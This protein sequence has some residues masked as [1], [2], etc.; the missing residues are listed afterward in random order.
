ME[1]IKPSMGNQTARSEREKGFTGESLVREQHKYRAIEKENATHLIF[2]NHAGTTAMLENHIARPHG[3]DPTV[4][5]IARMSTTLAIN[6]ASSSLAAPTYH[7]QG[8]LPS[9]DGVG[10]A[11]AAS[12]CR[13]Q[14]HRVSRKK[15]R[16]HL[17]L[18]SSHNPSEDFSD[19]SNKDG[20]SDRASQSISPCYM[21]RSFGYDGNGEPVSDDKS[22]TTKGK[23]VEKDDPSAVHTDVTTADF[24]YHRPDHD[25]EWHRGA[26]NDFF[27]DLHEKEVK[28]MMA[29]QRENTK[30]TP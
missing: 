26:V 13:Q 18:S 24:D 15:L 8:Y 10:K 12:I 20:P 21:P 5:P 3:S 6:K 2:R 11:R 1:P 30:T 22:N 19:L 9:Y 29:R 14:P 17:P 25:N 16:V 4:R 7:A 28:N 27:R 23:P